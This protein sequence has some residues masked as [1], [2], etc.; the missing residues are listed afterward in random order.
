MRQ[1][2]V[3][4]RLCW[5]KI[6]L[7]QDCVEITLCWD[8]IV[9]RQ[10]CVETR[11]CWDNTLTKTTTTADPCTEYV[12]ETKIIKE[13]KDSIRHDVVYYIIWYFIT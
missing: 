7:R 4:T 2:C 8:K 11:L 5:D 1:D 3:E 6:V 9:L 10:D 13:V 12:C